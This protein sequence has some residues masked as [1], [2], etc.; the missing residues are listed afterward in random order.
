MYI[1]LEFNVVLLTASSKNLNTEVT[2]M[3]H[4]E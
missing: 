3:N 4:D 1:E 2:I